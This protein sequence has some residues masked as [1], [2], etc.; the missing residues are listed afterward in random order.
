MKPDRLAIVRIPELAQVRPAA[1]LFPDDTGVTW[2]EPSYRDPVP[3]TMPAVHRLDGQL[4]A[5]GDGFDV[6]DGDQVLA[7]VRPVE[8]AEDDEDGSCARALADFTDQLVA[9]GVTV[10]EERGNVADVL[11]LLS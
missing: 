1:F 3:A 2:V 6:L 5:Q 7:T 9:A 11:E 10:E 8:T 4:S